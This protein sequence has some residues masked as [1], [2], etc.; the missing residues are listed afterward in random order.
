MSSWLTFKYNTLAWL[1]MLA[2]LNALG[3]VSGL[4]MTHNKPQQVSNFVL[5]PSYQLCMQTAT[6]LIWGGGWLTR[7]KGALE[8]FHVFVCLTDNGSFNVIVSYVNLIQPLWSCSC[9]SDKPRDH[10]NIL[11]LGQNGL[12]TT[13][14]VALCI[15]N[16]PHVINMIALVTPESRG[17]RRLAVRWQSFLCFNHKNIPSVCM[18]NRKWASL[19]GY[20][21]VL[22]FSYTTTNMHYTFF[23]WDFFV[24]LYLNE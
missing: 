3:S 9:G 24:N 12:D 23:G 22:C 20:G 2:S 14:P 18:F 1:V 5:V 13:V 21:G 17:W 6:D 7:M 10:V 16:R 11:N 8:A 4:P 19:N 15:L